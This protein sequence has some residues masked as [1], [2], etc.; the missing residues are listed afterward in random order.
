MCHLLS[1]FSHGH[2][3][4]PANA[5]RCDSPK[6][7]FNMLTK[8][9]QSV[10]VDWQIKDEKY[11]SHL[12]SSGFC[13]MLPSQNSFGIGS[14]PIEVK[15]SSA[16]SNIFFW[17]QPWLSIAPV[18]LRL[19]L[20]G[21]GFKMSPMLL[22]CWAHL[23]AADGQEDCLLLG[24]DVSTFSKSE[25][26]HVSEQMCRQGTTRLNLKQEMFKTKKVSR[27]VPTLPGYCAASLFRT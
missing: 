19:G 1:I 9:Q 17:F 2:R 23:V 4:R 6:A 11:I 16:F 12:P 25:D 13:K 10:L 21:Y 20:P 5:H 24:E 3:H 26:S 27:I 14:S 8:C 22:H 7:S 15:N 18:T